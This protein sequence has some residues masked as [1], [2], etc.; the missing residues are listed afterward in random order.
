M[1]K[2]INP[3]DCS[4]EEFLREHGSPVSENRMLKLDYDDNNL[5][6]AHVDNGAFTAAII[7]YC[8]GELEYIKSSSSSEFRPIKYFLVK[9]KYLEDF[10]V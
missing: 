10:L 3:E 4:K 1:G 7:C 6:C 2:Y 9:R 8:H 5:L